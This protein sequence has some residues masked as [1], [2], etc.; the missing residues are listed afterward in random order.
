V[1]ELE[2]KTLLAQGNHILANEGVLDAFGHV[3]AR[4]PQRSDR[5]M[6]SRSLSPAMVSVDDIMQ[7]DL[8]GNPCDGD[9]RNSYLERFIHAAIYAARPDVGAIVHHHSH[10]VIPFGV[11]GTQLQP[12][13]HLAAAMGPVVPLWDIRD[14]FGDTN[15]LVSNMAQGEDLTATLGNNTVMLIRGHGAVVTGN[16]V[17][18][19]V[20]TTIYMQVNAEL[21][22]KSFALGPIK[23]LSEGE[24]RMAAEVLLSPGP[25]TRAWE[26]LLRR[27]EEITPRSPTVAPLPP[28]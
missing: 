21:L 4:H 8:R 10:G 1:D 24:T 9:P 15:M 25:S 23:P 12:I 18:S 5:F 22:L 16:S 3:S 13:M 19:A 28:L 11:A 17:V 20:L 14:R 26:H 7:I 27:A 6:I 2:I